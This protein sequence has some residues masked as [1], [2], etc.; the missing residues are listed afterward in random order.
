MGVLR[1]GGFQYKDSNMLHSELQSKKKEAMPGTSL[2]SEKVIRLPMF[3]IIA[4]NSYVDH[5][6]EE[7]YKNI[8]LC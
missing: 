5:A 3:V 1:Q 4:L 7:I 8:H 6:Q 2:K